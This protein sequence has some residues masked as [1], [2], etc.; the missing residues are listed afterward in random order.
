MNGYFVPQPHEK[1][2]PRA[3]KRPNSKLYTMKEL[4]HCAGSELPLHLDVSATK[5]EEGYAVYNITTS[6]VSTQNRWHASYRYSEFLAF[7]NQVEEVWTCH[8]EKCQGSCQSLRDLIEACFP[9]KAGIM[10]TWPFTVEDR[11]TKFKNVLIHLLRSVLLPGSTMK[12]FHA[13]QHLPPAL[14]EF[15]GIADD[16]DKRSLLQVYVDNHQGGMKKSASHTGLSSLEHAIL[17]M[18]KMNSMKKS[19][20][21]SNLAQMELEAEEKGAAVTVENQQCMICLEDV[22]DHVHAEGPQGLVTLPCKHSFHRE[23]IFEWLLFQ[24]HCPLCRARVGPPAVA[25]YCRVKNHTFQWWL[26][27]FD[28]NPLGIKLA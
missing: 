26:S 8:D 9:K 25:S 11:K 27:K 23:C 10:S 12:C 17:G 18:K 7:R 1:P 2:A 6:S 21:T 22:E 15:L 24:F 14:F 13:R 28:E 20:T 4:R 19:A 3:P 16:A 5:K